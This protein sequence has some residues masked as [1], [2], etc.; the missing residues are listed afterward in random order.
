[1][2]LETAIAETVYHFTKFAMDSHDPARRE[3]MRVLL[4]NINAKFD[5]LP[6]DSTRASPLHKTSYVH[7]QA[8]D[9]ERR[10]DNSDGIVYS[11]VRMAEGSAPRHFGRMS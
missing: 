6:D 9:L 4:G 10:S 1:M 3:D 8:F 7:R 11:S 5:D 2:T